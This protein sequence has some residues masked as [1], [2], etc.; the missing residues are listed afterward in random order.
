[1]ARDNDPGFFVDFGIMPQE[2]LSSIALESERSSPWPLFDTALAEQQKKNW[3]SALTN[4]QKFLDQSPEIVGVLQAAV[5]YNNM[6]VIAYEKGDLLKAYVW[7]KKALSLNPGSHHAREAF[8]HYSKKFEVPS[9]SRQIS[10]YDNF[11]KLLSPVPVDF[12]ALLSVILLFFS[13]R[14]FMKK[15]I[16]RK[17]N[18][19]GPRFLSLSDWPAFV[20]VFSTLLVLSV[21]YIRYT[22]F[23]TPRALVS[24]EKAQIQTAPGE[25]KPIIFEAPAGLELEVL[26]FDQGY[27]QVRYA[28]TFSGWISQSQLELLSLYFEQYK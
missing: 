14:T 7:S 26:N 2:N 10:N 23:K 1:M 3:D 18:P 12:F 21:T 11:K 4:Y 28:G 19:I 24:V 16:A 17:Q 25:N 5:V 22:D 8:V 15:F 27:F 6:S 9:L 13:V 20:L